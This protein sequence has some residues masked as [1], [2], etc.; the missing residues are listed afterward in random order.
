[1]N[2]NENTQ[3]QK[4]L[5]RELKIKVKNRFKR[6]RSSPK[7]LLKCLLVLFLIQYVYTFSMSNMFV[8]LPNVSIFLAMVYLVSFPFANLSYIAVVYVL[9]WLIDLTT[10][11]VKMH[12][13]VKLIVNTVLLIIIATALYTISITSQ[14]AYYYTSGRIFNLIYFEIYINYRNLLHL[15]GDTGLSNGPYF[16]VS[17]YIGS[18]WPIATILIPIYYSVKKQFF[19][20]ETINQDEIDRYNMDLTTHQQKLYKKY[21]KKHGAYKPDFTWQRFSHKALAGIG[22]LALYISALLFTFLLNVINW[23]SGEKFILDDLFEMLLM[24]I[25]GICLGLLGMWLL[26]RNKKELDDHYRISAYKINWRINITITILLIFS[27]VGTFIPKETKSIG[28]EE[29]PY[30]VAIAIFIIVSFVNSLLLRRKYKKALRHSI[31]SVP[32]NLEKEDN[33]PGIIGS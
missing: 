28:S 9:F 21:I 6:L 4:S 11:K 3:K 18:L 22:Y 29:L 5:M 15:L 13:V 2:K 8:T 12:S 14:D 26:K 1:M 20:K 23:I 16:D 7:G 25:V 10:S 33:D 30:I 27:I 19:S 17:Y 32:K 24:T 31:V